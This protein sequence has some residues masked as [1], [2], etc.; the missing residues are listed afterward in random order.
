MGILNLPS[1]VKAIGVEVDV[2]VVSPMN[3]SKQCLSKMGN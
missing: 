3:G 2:E 1:F